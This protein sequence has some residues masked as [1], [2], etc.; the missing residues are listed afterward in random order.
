MFVNRSCLL[1]LIIV[2]LLCRTPASSVFGRDDEIHLQDVVVVSGAPGDDRSGTMFRE[3]AGR[4][5]A[6]A[7]SA[8]ATL[9]VIG[10]DDDPSDK[11][12]L[13]QLIP[14]RAAI[15]TGEPLWIVLIGHGTF[16]GRTARFNLR[17]PD[18]SATELAGLLENAQR[19]VA[20]I[21]CASC[22]APFINAVSGADRVIVTATKDGGQVQLARFGDA[23]SAAIG[24]TEADLDQDSQVSLLDAWAF[25]V[26]RTAEFYESSGRLATEHALL[27]DNGDGLG[28]RL[29]AFE[30][31]RLKAKDANKKTDGRLARRWHLIRS[32]EERRLSTAQRQRRDELEL[33]LE[34]ITQHRDRYEEAEYLRQ[35]ES[36]LIPLARLYQEVDDRPPV[37]TEQQ[38]SDPPAVGEQNH[39]SALNP[40]D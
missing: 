3:W 9:H 25:A 22:S 16:D 29:E 13:V 10:Q 39:N 23:M 26:R 12:T 27:D 40:R 14:E 19:P 15:R 7:E 32:D 20:V 5:K 8:D 33:R 35:L 18:L 34:E 24:G 28:T 38:P 21:N 17:G 37:E 2:I 4:W 36:V 31:V 6:A 11:Q 30:G 1:L